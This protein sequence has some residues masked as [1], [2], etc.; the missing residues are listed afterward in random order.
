MLDQDKRELLHHK[1][2]ELKLQ[3]SLQEAS[4]FRTNTSIRAH[5]RNCG[6]L[7]ALIRKYYDDCLLTCLLRHII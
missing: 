1:G 4:N 5:W 7:S 3:L 2:K 6:H